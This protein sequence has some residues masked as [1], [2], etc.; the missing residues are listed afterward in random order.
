VIGRRG[1]HKT[2]LADRPIHSLAPLYQSLQHV[3]RKFYLLVLKDL[4][5][6]HSKPRTPK[7]R[8]WIRRPLGVKRQPFG[9]VLAARF[10]VIGQ[11]PAVWRVDRIEQDLAPLKDVLLAPLAAAEEH[12]DYVEVGLEA[13]LALVVVGI[14]PRRCRAPTTA[15]RRSR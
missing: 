3:A 8:G 11:L 5:E 12:L 6:S 7:Q 14:A 13:G 2:G 9:I 4:G 10:D 15:P 1:R